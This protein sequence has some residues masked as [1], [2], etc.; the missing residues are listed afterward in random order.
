MS[1]A[2][3]TYRACSILE[4]FSGEEHTEEEAI[5]ALQY[6]IDTGDAWRLQGF[7]GRMAARAIEAGVCTA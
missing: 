2:M 6:L 7:Y 5:A 1:E 4:G 3:T